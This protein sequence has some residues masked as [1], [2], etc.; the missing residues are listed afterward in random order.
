[1]VLPEYGSKCNLCEAGI[2]P[3]PAEQPPQM[4]FVVCVP[5]VLH[6]CEYRI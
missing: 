4:F 3:S 1:L 2:F 6:V 5:V